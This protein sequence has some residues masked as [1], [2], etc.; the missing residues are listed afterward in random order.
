MSLEEGASGYIVYHIDD[1]G[2]AKRVPSTYEDGKVTFETDSCKI[3][4]AP[5]CRLSFLV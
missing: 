5:S 4:V 2:V 1:K 3:R